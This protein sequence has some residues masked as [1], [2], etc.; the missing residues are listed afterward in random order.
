M[1][2]MTNRY[3]LLQTGVLDKLTGASIP[4]D[5]NNRQY[6]EYLQWVALG[7]TPD[8]ERTQQEID[9]EL[10]QTELTSLKEDLVR[11]A[12]FQFR[13]IEELWRILKMHTAASNSDLDPILA[14]KFTEL[15][16][17]SDRLKEIDN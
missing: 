16:A 7:N 1:S 3:K 10:I 4:A 8:P 5:V 17:K 13:L 11:A 15:K 12:R 6:R 2:K 9:D 14:A